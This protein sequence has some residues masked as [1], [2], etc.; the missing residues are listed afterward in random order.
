MRSLTALKS[1]SPLQVPWAFFGITNA[2]DDQPEL[3]GAGDIFFCFN[4]FC[5]FG[6]ERLA[7]LA[8]EP[9]RPLGSWLNSYLGQDFCFT[10]TSSDWR[11]WV[12]FRSECGL[13][14]II[15]SLLTEHFGPGVGNMLRRLNDSRN[16]CRYHLWFNV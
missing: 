8:T 4:Q 12:N 11:V 13:G 16:F 10:K 7:P 2:G 14:I 1:I 9:H 5:Y 3:G 15:Q 6:N